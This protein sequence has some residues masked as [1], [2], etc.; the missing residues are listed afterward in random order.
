MDVLESVRK[1]TYISLYILEVHSF[2]IFFRSS[3][4]KFESVMRKTKQNIRRNQLKNTSVKLSSA[5]H[6]VPI[7]HNL[8]KLRE[9]RG[10]HGR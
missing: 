7:P 10:I 6:P 2:K 9:H 3:I 1:Y 8:V 5:S 4:I